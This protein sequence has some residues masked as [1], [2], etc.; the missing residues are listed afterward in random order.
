MACHLDPQKMFCRTQVE[1]ILPNCQHSV[2]TE[3]GRSTDGFKCKQP[4]QKMLCG[5]GHPCKKICFQPCGPCFT[6][7][8][9][10]LQCGHILVTECHVNLSKKKCR[11][12]KESL[13]PACGHLATINCGDD[14]TEAH[15]SLPCDVRLD[16]GH[17]CTLR[18][19][20]KKDPDHVNYQCKKP[21]CRMK[22]GCKKNHA[23]G[24]KCFEEC[25]P[26]NEKWKR[27]LPCGHEIFTEC[28]LDDDKI[29]CS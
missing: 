3:C 12:R 23:C 21:C 8:P 28:H 5:D 4:C 13:L 6:R 18:C 25:N 24:K 1:K 22:Q 15:C 29:F 27:T 14:S 20:V 19:H 9:K 10:T 11:V 26:C 17:T 16:C 7:V 2:Q